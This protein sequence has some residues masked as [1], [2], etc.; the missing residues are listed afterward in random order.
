MG[1]WNALNTPRTDETILKG[2]RWDRSNLGHHQGLCQGDRIDECSYPKSHLG[3]RRKGS[4]RAHCLLQ[5]K[6]STFS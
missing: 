5:R 3:E 2:V 4:G 1:V 6:E